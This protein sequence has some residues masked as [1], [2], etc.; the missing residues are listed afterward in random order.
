MSKEKPTVCFV[1]EDTFLLEIY[2]NHLRKL[3]FDPDFATSVDKAMRILK[4]REYD[5][6]VID[7]LVEKTPGIELLEK[8]IDNN[9][10]GKRATVVLT[11]HSKG[12][13]IKK[14]SDLGVSG[15]IVKPHNTPEEVAQEIKSLYDREE[16]KS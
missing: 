5:V 1:D 12:D 15:Y 6:V 10:G 2:M 8:I 7:V 13:D 3:G 11:N 9:L 4:E 14:A 16:I